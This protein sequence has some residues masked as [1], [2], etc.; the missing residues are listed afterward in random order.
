LLDADA[1]CGQET[2]LDRMPGIALS[3]GPG[4]VDRFDNVARSQGDIACDILDLDRL[5]AEST[6]AVKVFRAFQ[7]EPFSLTQIHPGESTAP[8]LCPITPNRRSRLASEVVDQRWVLVRF[9]HATA[10]TA[11]S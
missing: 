8:D 2:E 7:V 3:V 4:V 6:D 10:E 9:H 1:A 11:A 5:C